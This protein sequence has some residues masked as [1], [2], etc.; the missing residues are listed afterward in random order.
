MKTIMEKKA[1]QNKIVGKT[2][3]VLLLCVFSSFTTWAQPAWTKKATKSVFTVKTFN[4]EGALIGS[5]NGF[6]VNEQGDGV[7]SFAP[8]KGASRAVV[9]D[10]QGNEM[11]VKCMLGANDTY[12]VAKFR[13]AAKKTTPLPMAATQTGDGTTVWLLPY[14]EVKTLP[15]GTIQKGET[16]MENHTYYTVAMTMPD[17]T[18]G[19][20]L[21]NEAGE[22][23]GLM[24]QPYKQGD[25]LS[26]AVGVK[27][28]NELTINGLSLNDATL[29]ST[30]IKKD[31][32]DDLGQAVFA[33]YLG[34]TALDSVSYTT[35][36][37][38][39]I[40]KFPNSPDGYEYRAQQEVTAGLF[41][42]AAQDMEKAIKV[43]EKKDE[44]HFNYSKLILSKEVYLSQNEYSKW[45]LDKAL[46]EAQEADRINPTPV[47]RHQQAVIFYAQKK[48]EEA[49]NVY[50]SLFNTEL[51][52]ASLFYE[53]SRCKDMVHDSTAVLALLDSC[54]ALYEKPYL[55]EAAPY[56][57]V[58]AQARLD[59]NLYRDAVNDFNDYEALMPTTVTDRFY[60][61]RH[62]AE[63]GGRLYQ[64]ALNDIDK[65]IT[66]SPTT[67]LYYGEKASLQIRVGQYKEAL[68]TA[69]E[70]I[71]KWPGQSDGYLFLGMAQCLMGQKTEGVKNLQKAGELGDTQAAALI[72]K[73]GK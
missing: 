16:F 44:T 50:A 70:L 35:L 30:Q 23:I 18:V 21:L 66:L 62:Q 56:L 15:Q 25:T 47:Y 73:Y 14:R 67:D 71:E 32:P 60:Y 49:Y 27:F 59:R 22:V 33:L 24:Q 54:V 39:F 11:E 40:N 7:S 38:D 53:A 63:I 9:I 12:D 69:K 19:C 48:Y 55:K 68:E 46:E 37:E 51:R 72:E 31:L 17:N 34:S 8:F 2:L 20:P 36:I 26:Y 52:S 10:G 64:Q 43:S 41:D 28:A 4:A 5:S 45:S 42:A 58:R 6:F 57:L 65:A 29:R 13:V 1:Y 61:M 3:S